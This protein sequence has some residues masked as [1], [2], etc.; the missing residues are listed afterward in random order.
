[1]VV[2]KI[3]G[4]WRLQMDEHVL[5]R[6]DINVKAQL[7]I[8]VEESGFAGTKDWYHNGQMSVAALHIP[9]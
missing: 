5:V 3:F 9:I 1:M 2:T 8:C 6:L 4:L 7:V